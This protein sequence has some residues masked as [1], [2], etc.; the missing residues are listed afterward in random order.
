VFQIISNS[1]V[2]L[3]MLGAADRLWAHL[4]LDDLRF[5]ALAAGLLQQRG[6]AADEALTLA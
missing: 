4:G 6:L 5:P 1:N 3:F 2:F